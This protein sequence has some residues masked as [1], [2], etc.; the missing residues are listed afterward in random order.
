MSEVQRRQFF[1][2]FIMKN[3]GRE[4]PLYTLL[5][6]QLGFVREIAYYFDIGLATI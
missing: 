2:T 6:I 1:R 4:N 5:H 3:I